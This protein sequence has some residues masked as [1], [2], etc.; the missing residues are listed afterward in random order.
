MKTRATREQIQEESKQDRENYQKT[1]SDTSVRKR[2]YQRSLR[3][4]QVILRAA[5]M[6]KMQ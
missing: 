5:I 6:L 2:K 4:T 1:F 3:R